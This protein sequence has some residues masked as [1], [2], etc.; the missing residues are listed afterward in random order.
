MMKIPGLS[1]LTVTRRRYIT[2]VCV[3]LLL[4]LTLVILVLVL[5]GRGPESG[6]ARGSGE[7]PQCWALHNYGQ[8]IRN[9][10]GIPGADIGSAGL[11]VKYLKGAPVIVGVV[12]TGID[13]Q[14]NSKTLDLWTNSRDPVD[15]KDN[16]HNHLTDDY[17][18]WDFYHNS[19][20]IFHDQLHDYHGTYIANEIAKVYPGARILSS[21]FLHGTTGDVRDAVKA[22]RYAV[23]NGASIINCSWSFDEENRELYDIMKRNNNVLFVCAAGNSRIDFDREKVYPAG[24]EDQGPDS[25]DNVISVAAMNNRAE[26]CDVSGYG[27]RVD[28]AAPGENIRVT[29]SPED[30]TF[31]SGT[32]VSTAY[33]SAAA[34]ILKSRDKQLSPAEIRELLVTG[35]RKYDSLKSKCRAG[36]C[37]NIRGAL[38]KMKSRKGG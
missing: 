6:K 1:P 22:V 16:D 17:R 2:R 29:L 9:V 10:K 5:N 34:A 3:L 7:D 21:K 32:S 24:F 12:D 18:G 33:V 35:A 36:G 13:Y 37:L 8:K 14:S 27:R 25:L 15:G 11:P 38:E 31:V 30:K 20:R 4:Q 19:N 28:L 23:R 26:I